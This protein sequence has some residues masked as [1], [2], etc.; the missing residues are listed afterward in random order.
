MVAA[1]A[2][3]GLGLA[4]LNALLSSAPLSGAL[5][6]VSVAAPDGRT[7]F[8][9][10]ESIR[11]VPGSNQK[12]LTAAFALERLGP[13]HRPVTRIWTRGGAVWVEAPGDPSWT[14]SE[15]VA[16]RERL[17]VEPGSPVFVKQAYR[18]EV[19]PGWEL[20][21]LPNRYAAQVRAWT[22]DRGGFELWAESGKLRPLP[23]ELGVSVRRG[24]GNGSLSIKFNPITGELGVDGSLQSGPTLIDTLAIPL[25]DAAASRFLGG[26]QL[27]A[28]ALPSWAPAHVRAGPTVQ[29][30]VEDCLARSDNQLA[31]HLLLM[32]SAPYARPED[33]YPGARAS[34]MKTLAP[35]LGDWG[36]DF[37]PDDGSGLS[38][39]NLVTTRAISRLLVWARSRPWFSGFQSALARPGVGTL[40]SRLSGVDFV[41]KTGTLDSV[42][43]L[44]GYLRSADGS[45]LV[46]SV[47]AN[48]FVAPASQVRDV[49]DRI[50]AT[51]ASSPVLWHV[52][53]P[54][55]EC[56]QSSDAVAG[57]GPA[58]IDRVPRSRGD[59][60]A[61][62]PR[63]DLGVE[64]ADEAA[65]R[66]VRVAFR[67]GQGCD[68]GRGLGRY[69]P[70]RPSEPRIRP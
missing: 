10:N 57:A 40:A 7:L 69:G 68:P 61:A 50:V 2:L 5:V 6:A 18:P 46:V 27:P 54:T 1:L 41:G 63:S 52:A 3:L 51:I 34:L 43:A 32:A 67:S 70:L 33:P 44:S 66:A 30:I 22:V 39:H 15:L 36:D 48:H 64:S 58:H 14:S 60:V 25:P 19:P 13:D 26:S 45:E 4:D 47:I 24:A 23:P 20:D 9:R 65:H 56:A 49:L 37:R 17:K 8:A 62:R 16:L 31:E 35:A 59:R 42:A 11:V 12:L 53:C 29:K 28:G 21:D 38:R 55:A